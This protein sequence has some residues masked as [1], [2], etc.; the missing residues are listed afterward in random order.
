LRYLL[1]RPTRKLTL[2][3]EGRELFDNTMPLIDGLERG[4]DNLATSIAAPIG[5]LNITAPTAFSRGALTIQIATFIKQHA[6]V[7]LSFNYT[8]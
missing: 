4:I 1:Y 7:K 3:H 5:Q 6:K 8:D 2:T